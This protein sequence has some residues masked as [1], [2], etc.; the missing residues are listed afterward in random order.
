MSLPCISGAARNG[1]EY[2]RS[3]TGTHREMGQGR[4]IIGSII[5]AGGTIGNMLFG[6]SGGYSMVTSTISYD[7]SGAPMPEFWNLL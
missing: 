2:R 7:F 1:I 5:G 4:G 3:T 6:G